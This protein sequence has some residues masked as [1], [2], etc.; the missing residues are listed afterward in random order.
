[1][2]T[3]FKDITNVLRKGADA[4]R[5]TVDSANYKDYVLAMLAFKC[6][7]DSHKENSQKIQ[8]KD[9]QTLSKKWRCDFDGR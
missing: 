8:L 5:G 1:M 4:F 3:T 6:I 2:G 9:Y 7:C